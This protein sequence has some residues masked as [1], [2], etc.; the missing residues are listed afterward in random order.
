MDENEQIPNIMDGDLKALEI[1]IHLH[2]EKIVRFAY[3]YG[4]PIEIA[5]EVATQTFEEFKN[6]TGSINDG[7]QFLPELYKIIIRKVGTLQPTSTAQENLFSFEEDA[8]LHQDIG[9]LDANIRIP[10]ILSKFHDFNFEEIAIV[11]NT[12]EKE[13]STWIDQA[14]QSLQL[15]HFDK[16]LELLNKS[17]NRLPIQFKEERITESKT[18][19]KIEAKTSKSI[20]WAVALSTLLAGI[21]ITS[22]FTMNKAETIKT[23]DSEYAVEYTKL[24]D[25]Y[26]EALMLTNER[27]DKLAF[28]QSAD[29]QMQ[30][31][32][33]S[34]KNDLLEVGESDYEYIL[35]ELK[36]PS[37]M[38]KDFPTSYS[39][40]S[41][42]DKS[43]EFLSSYR[44][45]SKDIISIYS[46]VLWDYRLDVESFET[47]GYGNKAEQ[48]I[49]FSDE[50]PEELKSVVATMH[51]HSITLR[52]DKATGKIEPHLF[53]T[54]MYQDIIYSLHD[55]VHGYALFIVNE[56]YLFEEIMKLS[57]AESFYHLLTMQ[58]TLEKVKQDDYLYP[59]MYE[60][61]VEL[62]YKF[63]KGS[64][65]LNVFD[66]R[67][68]VKNEFKQTWQRYSEMYGAHP[69]NYLFTPIVEE[70]EA[71]GWKAS[72]S[73]DEFDRSKIEE[74]LKLSKS[75]ELEEIMYGKP[76]H[77]DDD[78]VVLTN[79]SFAKEV[80]QL[81][82]TFKSSYDILV[83]KGKSPI[84]TVGVYD[85][86]N[87]LNDPETM[88]H[89]IYD[90]NMDYMGTGGVQSQKDFVSK[91]KK[92]FS[93]FKDAQK[94]IFYSGSMNRIGYDFL[95]DV[96][97][98]SEKM[99]K[100]ISVYLDKEQ[101]W[102]LHSP[103]VE[104]L[105]SYQLE[106]D[107]EINEN[108]KNEAELFYG[109]VSMDHY[110]LMMEGSRAIDII[111][112]YLYAGEIGDYQAQYGLFVQ[113][114]HADT[115]ELE[116]YIEQ[117]SSFEPKNMENHYS[118]ISFTGLEQD[119]NGQWP[120]V[121]TLTSNLEENPEAEPEITIP[122]R[123]TEEGW[124]IVY[125]SNLFTE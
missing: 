70:M 48:M 105:P 74:A 82:D 57:Y 28:I 52:E 42:E 120:G 19:S 50:L 103:W 110:P 78:F 27:F 63:V 12:T 38:L 46:E 123:W 124:R 29:K 3:Q 119:E 5:L 97:I 84:Y 9:K 54:A 95:A 37:Q 91:W 13:V 26:K 69:T 35:N 60:E 96:E 114:E 100:N 56:P 87:E 4:L 98:I 118:K 61:Y 71:T 102:Y 121:A 44:K 14:E 99:H 94:S 55:N 11:L 40:M 64:K 93:L 113:D 22:F 68:I 8:E 32:L 77:I 86:A 88:Y 21:L 58:D 62:F 25:A 108:F 33:E 79:E 65:D 90:D 117:M 43:I 6:E 101:N 73:W 53:L 125:T 17:Y 80:K 67:G 16:R 36:I 106:E 20:R 72:K 81:Y 41:D 7:K 39:L 116:V 34:E 122:M 47:V 115:I 75:D 49:K 24:R 2:S 92:G 31:F 1:W 59:D 109:A 18:V 104:E 15:N 66:G 51:D 10:I 111:G 45:K 107:I 85:Y 112:I 30:V 23:S 89:L 76:P 83:F